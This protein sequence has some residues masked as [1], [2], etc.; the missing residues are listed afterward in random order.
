MLTGHRNRVEAMAREV[1]GP[2]TGMN[3]IGKGVWKQ[4][5]I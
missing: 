2:S 4:N 3:R 1:Q 5:S